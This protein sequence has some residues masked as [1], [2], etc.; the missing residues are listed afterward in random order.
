MSFSSNYS[1]INIVKTHPTFFFL[2]NAINFVVLKV[3]IFLYWGCISFPS[4]RIIY[5]AH[6]PSPL[7][8]F[9]NH[10]ALAEKPASCELIN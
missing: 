10:L 8:V 9:I 1:A 6:L 2:C 5:R 4:V 7:L 3:I